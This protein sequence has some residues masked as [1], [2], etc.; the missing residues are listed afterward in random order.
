MTEGEKREIV[1]QVKEELLLALPDIIGNLIMNHMNLRRINKKFYG[2]HPEL[3]SHKD[4][5]ASIVEMVEGQNPGLDYKAIL[6]LAIPLIRN[7]IKISK[8]LNM[9]KVE[10]PSRNLS[11]LTLGNGEL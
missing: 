8:P 9:T 5:V 11:S 10:R 4:T 7:Q 1:N 3:A 6:D 2:D